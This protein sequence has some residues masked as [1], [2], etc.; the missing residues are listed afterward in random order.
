MN[1]MFARKK[2]GSVHQIADQVS[3]EEVRLKYHSQPTKI[4]SLSPATEDEYREYCR[5]KLG[6]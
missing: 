4:T 5:K 6:N 3:D 2:D 1:S